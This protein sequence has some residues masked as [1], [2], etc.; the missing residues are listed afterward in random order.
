MRQRGIATGVIGVIPVV[1][2][3]LGLARTARVIGAGVA[4]GPGRGKTGA[5]SWSRRRSE[6]SGVGANGCGCAV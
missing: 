4:A 6:A 3:L 1:L 5:A 2:L